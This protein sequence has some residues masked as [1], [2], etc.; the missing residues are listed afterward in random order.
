MYIYIYTYIHT[1]I[2]RAKH[3]IIH[4]LVTDRLWKRRLGNL[5]RCCV[6]YCLR[7]RKL[8]NLNPDDETNKK[9][10]REESKS[11]ST[12]GPSPS[13]ADRSTTATLSRP[14]R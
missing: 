8:V 1:Y 10:A 4:R 12:G 5:D 6:E 3:E 13:L 2:Y 7:V 14:S 11:R 9:L